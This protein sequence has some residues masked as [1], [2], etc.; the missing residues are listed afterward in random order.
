MR[1]A[2]EADEPV[3]IA[4]LDDT[5]IGHIGQNSLFNTKESLVDLNRVV[6]VIRTMWGVILDNCAG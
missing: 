5:H 4:A 2:R 3:H 6:M 1:W